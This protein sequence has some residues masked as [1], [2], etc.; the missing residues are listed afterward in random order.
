VRFCSEHVYFQQ[1]IVK[2]SQKKGISSLPILPD[3][4]KLTPKT[5]FSAQNQTFIPKNYPKFFKFPHFL[6]IPMTSYFI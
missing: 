3:Y 6:K 5:S 2:K 1:K 4:Y